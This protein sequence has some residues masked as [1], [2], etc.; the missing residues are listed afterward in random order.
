MPNPAGFEFYP[1][2]RLPAVCRDGVTRQ[3]VCTGYAAQ[4]LPAAVQ[5]YSGG[6]RRT[7]SGTVYPLP[8]SRLLSF[9]A[10]GRNADLIPWTSHK[11]RLARAALRLIKATAY[12]HGA[13]GYIWDSG[14]AHAAALAAACRKWESAAYSAPE[15]GH[16]ATA[17][18]KRLPPAVLPRLAIFFDKQAAFVRMDENRPV[19][20]PRD[21]PA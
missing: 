3:A 20:P 5:I 19:P 16:Q 15:L 12:G 11:P 8:F 6:K 7:V 18:F 10:T 21:L 17:V 13:P 4:G 9:Y 2:R 1:G 14:A